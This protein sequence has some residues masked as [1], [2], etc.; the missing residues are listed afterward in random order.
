M[1]PAPICPVHG[2]AMVKRRDR[3]YYLCQ[4]CASAKTKAWFQRVRTKPLQHLRYKIKRNS[5]KYGITVAEYVAKW[6]EQDGKCQ[7]CHRPFGSKT[8]H[9]D[10]SHRGDLRTRGLLCSQCNHLIGHCAESTQRLQDA[11]AY[12][13]YWSDK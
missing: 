7:I 1:D 6:V 8:P 11:I 4:P 9:I 12:L 13:E 10:H 3:N 2:I 5:A